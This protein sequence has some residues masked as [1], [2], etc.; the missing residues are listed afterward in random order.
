VSSIETL[1]RIAPEFSERTD[2][3]E[4]LFQAAANIN[5]EAWGN[6]YPLGA[7]YLAA[8]LLTQSVGAAF[9]SGG[10]GP[11][12]SVREGDLSLSFGSVS[13][14]GK[15]AYYT[16]TKYGVEFLRMR[17]SLILTPGIS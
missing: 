13:A 11:I 2:L 9:A 8:H 12:T 7:A 15:N 17:S 14:A 6:L 10:A 1:K 3:K 16:T 4:W 5:P